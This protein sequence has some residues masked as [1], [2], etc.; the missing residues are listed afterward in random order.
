MKNIDKEKIRLLFGDVIRGFSSAFYKDNHLY[1]KH[2]NVLD[3]SELDYQKSIFYN[4][5]IDK[6]LQ[7]FSEK[8]KYLID[9]NLWDEDKNNK[10]KNL[11]AQIKNLKVTKSKLFKQTDLS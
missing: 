10:I 7:T 3:S 6:G 1:L 4:Q 5:A 8:E 2:L 9:E 11:T